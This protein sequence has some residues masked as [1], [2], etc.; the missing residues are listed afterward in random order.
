MEN[1]KPQNVIS[2]LKEN[3]TKPEVSLLSINDNTLG[4]GTVQVDFGVDNG[5]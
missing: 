5:S 4:G 1:L 2:E 3:W